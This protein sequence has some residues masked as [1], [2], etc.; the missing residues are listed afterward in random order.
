MQREEIFFD[1]EKE[2]E[3]QTAKFPEQVVWESSPLSKFG[4][5]SEE[6]FE[7]MLEVNRAVNDKD[8]SKLVE[9][10]IQVAAVAVKWLESIPDENELPTMASL[11]GL[12]TIVEPREF[13]QYS[14]SDNHATGPFKKAGQDE[15]EAS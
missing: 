14:R 10:L 5:L 1:I 8:Y 12:N 2:R 15:K 3:R 13:I 9:E 11:T 7:A 4:V 6:F